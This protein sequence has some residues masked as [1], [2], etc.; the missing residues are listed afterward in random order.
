M[1]ALAEGPM[2]GPVHLNAPFAEPLVPTPQ[3]LA[4]LEDDP[5]PRA[6]SVS[7]P[8]APAQPTAQGLVALQG[9]LR[10][11]PRGVIVCGP[12]PALCCAQARTQAVLDLAQALAWP[13]LADPLSGLRFGAAATHRPLV[14]SRY[15]ALLKAGRT[16]PPADGVL[17]LGG[18]PTSKALQRWLAPLAGR[19]LS[20]HEPERFEAADALASLTVGADVTALCQSLLAAGAPQG[21]AEHLAA[22]Q[23]WDAKGAPEPVDDLGPLSQAS[24]WPAV[25]AALPEGAGLHV[26][27]SMPVRGL[28]TFSGAGAKA[29]RISANRGLNG[30]DGCIATLLGLALGDRRPWLG[31]LGDLTFLHDVG[32]LQAA[33]QGPVT[34]TLV[35]CNNHG[36]AIFGGL[37]IAQHT[38]VFERYFRTP[39][40]ADLGLLCAAC[41]CGHEVVYTPAGLRQAVATAMAR[42]EDG[43]L[44]VIEALFDGAAPPCQRGDGRQSAP[45]QGAS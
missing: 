17:V 32:A 37:P 33:R 23:C 7:V 45:P 36:G 35:V 18:L 29:L 2:A 34:V 1:V 14:L 9:F 31:V 13:I 19:I 12:L 38:D 43:R 24:L 22:W 41:A 11:H 4:R 39:Q 5:G 16:P 40:A 25:L 20:V 15:D 10:A 3:N 27:S 44:H 21:A 8:M 30:I 26:G 42:P 6:P 28:D